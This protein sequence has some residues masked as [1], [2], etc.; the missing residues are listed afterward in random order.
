MTDTENA[1]LKRGVARALRQMPIMASLD[2]LGELRSIVGTLRTVDRDTSDQRRGIAIIDR[3]IE[4]LRDQRPLKSAHS[5]RR[6]GRW[7]EGEW[8]AARAPEL[9][10]VR[11][12]LQRQME[13]GRCDV[14]PPK[15][16][17]ARADDH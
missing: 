10:L 17:E 7:L 15:R 4:R 6:C 1:A 11:A 3:V 13:Q 8:N 12:D 16:D 5:C 14:C 9:H 2:D